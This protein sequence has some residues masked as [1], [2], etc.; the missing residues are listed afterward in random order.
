MSLLDVVILAAFYSLFALLCLFVVL[1]GL[2]LFVY[3]ATTEI[4]PGVIFAF[5]SSLYL[6]YIAAVSR[7]L[8]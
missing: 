6:A 3:A 5:F 1:G 8:L 7:K 4:G 2:M